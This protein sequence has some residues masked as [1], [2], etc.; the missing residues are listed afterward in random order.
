M[1]PTVS[2][3]VLDAG[4][5]RPAAGIRVSLLRGGEKIA[6]GVTDSSGRIA[7]LGGGLTA[8]PHRIS[9]ELDPYFGARDH[10]YARIDLDFELGEGPHHLP[11][12]I[13]PHSCTAYRGA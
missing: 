6:E 10:L 7:S 4:L 3:H 8:G 13:A 9:F 5:G 11:L 2:T 1:V 12:L